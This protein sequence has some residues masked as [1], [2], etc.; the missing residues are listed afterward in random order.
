M[1]LEYI[2]CGKKTERIEPSTHQAVEPIETTPK[3]QDVSTSSAPA[4]S[5]ST[6]APGTPV[7]CP[8]SARVFGSAMAAD[9][10]VEGV[11]SYENMRK[12]LFLRE[13]DSAGPSL[14]AEVNLSPPFKNNNLR[15]LCTPSS[16]ETFLVSS[17]E[18]IF[19]LPPSFATWAFPLPF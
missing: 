1:E 6:I 8:A 5:R 17:K 13:E 3:Q 12:E 7:Q 4:E 15:K 16:V 14:M 19:F 2:H 9:S 11:H 10:D 18:L